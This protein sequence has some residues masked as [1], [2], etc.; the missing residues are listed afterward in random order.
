MLPLRL[1]KYKERSPVKKK[2][3]EKLQNVLEVIK[4]CVAKGAYAFSLHFSARST[5]REIDVPTTLDVLLTGYEE[6]KKACF[7]EQ[8]NSW[9]YAIRG[10]TMD[11]LDIRVVVAI[12]NCGMLIITVMH[13][14]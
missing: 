4:E 12:D 13:V 2:R 14:L 3:P 5:E 9:K 8:R 1:D 6:K 10:K 7:D 11:D